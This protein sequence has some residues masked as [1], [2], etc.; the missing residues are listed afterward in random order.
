[1]SYKKGFALSLFIS[2]LLLSLIS[3]IVY[4]NESEMEK[5]EILNEIMAS[6]KLLY[7]FDDLSKDLE[8]LIRVKITQNDTQI[9]IEDE[10]PATTEM[11]TTI[12]EYMDFVSEHYLTPDINISYLNPNEDE[13]NLTEVE[14][15][16]IIEPW[17]IAYRYEDW[18]K[19]ELEIS[20]PELSL[21]LSSAITWGRVCGF[22]ARMTSSP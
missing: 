11:M 13:F 18:G 21:P 6:K 4:R 12:D 2:L 16:I 3:L 15:E 7:T 9:T 20:C 22:I 10:L 5:S 1:M 14:P 8:Y 17:N 19:R